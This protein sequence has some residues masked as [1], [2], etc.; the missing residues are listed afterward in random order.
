MITRSCR[1]VQKYPLFRAIVSKSIA[2]EKS[3]DSADGGE[4]PP[5]GHATIH[6]AP[7]LKSKRMG[8]GSIPVSLITAPTRAACLF[9]LR[10]KLTSLQGEL[11]NHG[12][13]VT[14][15][16]KSHFRILLGRVKCEFSEGILVTDPEKLVCAVLDNRRR[17]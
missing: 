4:N 5:I 15:Q 16:A 12:A 9:L 2:G 14:N 3:E 8:K 13:I 6:G 17:A 1:K 11:V 7:L 10:R